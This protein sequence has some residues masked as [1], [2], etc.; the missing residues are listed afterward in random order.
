M[1]QNNKRPKHDLIS[2]KILMRFEMSILKLSDADHKMCIFKNAILSLQARYVLSCQSISRSPD[3]LVFRSGIDFL[4]SA[5]LIQ[6]IPY[7]GD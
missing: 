2:L 5:G 7:F 4:V 1:S 6:E 3:I